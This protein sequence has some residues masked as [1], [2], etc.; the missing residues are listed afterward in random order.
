MHQRARKGQRLTDE[1]IGFITNKT[2]ELAGASSDQKDTLN[3]S[4]AR[5]AVKAEQVLSKPAD[6]ITQKDAREMA[7]KESQAFEMLP[8]TGS[9]ASHVQSVAERNQGNT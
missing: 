3:P 9:V 4:Q 6:G 5:W 1:E 8:A 2:A 7:S